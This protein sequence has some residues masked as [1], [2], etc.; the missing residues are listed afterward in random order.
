MANLRIHQG[1]YAPLGSSLIG[2]V[3]VTGSESEG[4]VAQ[5]AVA[6]AQRAIGGH[7]NDLESQLAVRAGEVVPLGAVLYRIAEVEA[8]T[9][10]PAEPAAPVHP[11]HGT[12]VIDPTPVHVAGVSLHPGSFVIPLHGSGELHGCEFEIDQLSERQSEDKSAL[13]AHI[14]LWPNDYQKHDAAKAGAMRRETVAV[15]ELL[16]LGHR[17]HRVLSIVPADPAHHLRGFIELDVASA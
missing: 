10:R 13:V 6:P 17:D 3:A 5:L 8:P 1:S 12:V 9:E 15:G 14:L 7:R 11:G 16:P 2:V 4:A